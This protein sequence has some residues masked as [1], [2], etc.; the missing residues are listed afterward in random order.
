VGV[1]F[2]VPEAGLRL[3]ASYDRA[4]ETPP[5]EGLL[6]ASS[7]VTRALTEESTGLA[8]RPTRSNFYQVGFAKSLLGRMRLDGNYY[9]RLSRNFTDDSLLLNTGIS[10]PITFDRATIHG[11]EAKLELPRWGRV[12][13]FL[14]YSNMTG[15]GRLPLTG[16]LF[17]EEDEAELLR[18]NT[19]FPITQDQRHT[20][21]AR[22]RVQVT[23]RFWVAGGGSYN[24]GLPFEREGDFDEDDLEERFSGRILERVNFERGRVLPQFSLDT[25]AGLD[26]MQGDRSTV[27]LQADTWN[28]TNRLNVINFSGL[29][30][31]TA[32]GVPRSGTV[33]LMWQF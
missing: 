5:V 7:P 20:A 6:L 18:M 15:T 23:K 1:A 28:L 12:S 17:L 22:F 13:G 3:H 25:S 4:F 29:F 21:R 24:S 32:I 19:T 2:H 16:G 11:V 14:S 27:R 33:R 8:L 30:S 31:G 10:F 9:R 26:L